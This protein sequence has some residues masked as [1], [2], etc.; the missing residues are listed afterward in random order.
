MFDAVVLDDLP[1]RR[2]ER[3]V[4]CRN[5]QVSARFRQACNDLAGHLHRERADLS[6]QL[7]RNAD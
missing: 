7:L 2:A 3:F 4:R 6:E 5:G 1:L